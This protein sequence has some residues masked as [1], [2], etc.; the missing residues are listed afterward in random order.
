M[1]IIRQQSERM[2]IKASTVENDMDEEE[3]EKSAL[4]LEEDRET[5]RVSAGMVWKSLMEF[6][7]ILGFLTILISSLIFGSMNLGATMVIVDWSKKYAESKDTEDIPMITGL[8]LGQSFLVIIRSGI[9][10]LVSVA[11]SRRIHSKMTFR[12]L[13]S[14]IGEF[15][16]RIPSGRI[17]NRFS[18][19]ID[20]IDSD[21]SIK[22]L[23]VYLFFALIVTDIFTIV[24]TTHQYLLL[25]PYVMF[26]IVGSIL[27]N[28]YMKAKADV[29][30]LEK[31]T[32]SPIVSWVGTSM[33]GLS[34]IRTLKKVTYV[35]EE[36]KG[37]VAENVKNPI[38]MYG[39][40][41]WFNARI[42]FANLLL[43]QIPCYG[44][45]LM[46]LYFP[47][48]L[49]GVPKTQDLVVFMLRAVEMSFNVTYFL[50]NSSDLETSLI[51]VERCKKFEKLEPEDQYLEFEEQFKNFRIPSKKQI[52]RYLE[53]QENDQLVTR[54]QVKFQN[55]YA[56]YPSR[57]VDAIR[58]ISLDVQPGEKIGI[59]GRTGAG[60]TSFIKMFW[61]ALK[62]RKGTITVDGVDVSTADLKKLR[63]GIMVVSQE[64]AI[65]EG[66]LRENLDPKLEYLYKEGSP[67][68]EENDK[69]LIDKLIELGFS[70]DRLE[71]NGLADMKIEND[72][73][74]L[75]QGEKQLVSFMRTLRNPR[76][77]VILDEATA[78]IDLETEKKIQL[79]IGRTFE[80]ST[81]FI[82]AH[83]IQTILDCDRVLV[84]ERG[85]VAEFDTP[86]RLLSKEGSIFG[87]IYAKLEEKAQH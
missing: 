47:E 17:L 22:L 32:R 72:G 13:H 10:A 65:F 35:K 28:K 55:V 44:Y 41:L 80:Q 53:E 38:L 64:T 63:N 5:G 27:Q 46:K 48:L 81:M 87:K 42:S 23:S 50:M 30:R 15:L 14:Q 71:Q 11:V 86:K 52:K 36:L 24:I 18:K 33:K 67:E 31:I 25:I 1:N 6:G 69:M 73:G 45:L 79:E 54:G 21:I 60:K 40:D 61:L 66:T 2:S 19:D 75:S 74:N 49:G 77:V 3:K 57:N 83:R 76:K 26:V 29:Q 12:V 7:G 84:L 58:R 68:R 8:L 85:S 43:V 78:N 56:R 34:E 20:S 16:E 70:R 39:L 51:S 82:I 59:V 62:S 9:I 37:L 4:F